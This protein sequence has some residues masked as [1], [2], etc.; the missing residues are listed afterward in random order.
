[1]KKITSICFL[2][3]VTLVTQ[4]QYR[5]NTITASAGL[6]IYNSKNFNLQI[7]HT[8]NKVSVGLIAESILYG[9]DESLKYNLKNNGH[10]FFTGGLFYKLTHSNR[11]FYR[12]IKVG[13]LAGVDHCK[14][15]AF[16]WYPFVALEEACCVQPGTQLFIAGRCSY[17]LQYAERN[18]QPALQFGIKLSQ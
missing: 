8:G 17:L 1:M 14:A 11:N 13:A 15:D 10:L 5:L 4:A 16:V 18:F 6:S 3:F 7:E 12:N 9:G 2:L